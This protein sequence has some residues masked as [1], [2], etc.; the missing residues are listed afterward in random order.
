[1]VTS[2]DSR[3]DST[4][5]TRAADIKCG[6]SVLIKYDLVQTGLSLNKVGGSR[7]ISFSFEK[8]ELPTYAPLTDDEVR[9]KI[10]WLKGDVTREAYKTYDWIHNPDAEDIIPDPKKHPEYYAGLEWPGLD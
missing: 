5:F 8:T 7:Q 9:K 3:V 6:S 2:I 1:M 10:D 4:N